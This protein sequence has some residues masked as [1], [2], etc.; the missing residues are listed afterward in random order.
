MEHLHSA[1]FE[2]LFLR[3]MFEFKKLFMEPSIFFLKSAV[4]ELRS[5]GERAARANSIYNKY[6]FDSQSAGF[7]TPVGIRIV[8][9]SCN[10]ID[11]RRLESWVG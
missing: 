4:W 3:R 9:W 6:M 10:Q 11:A 1:I 8:R 2:K 5:L 7:E